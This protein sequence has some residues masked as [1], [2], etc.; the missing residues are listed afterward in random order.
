MDHTT[1]K[2]VSV[3]EQCP[4]PL[5]FPSGPV[6]KSGSSCTTWALKGVYLSSA[7][8]C[9]VVLEAGEKCDAGTCKVNNRQTGG[10]FP[11]GRDGTY[12]ELALASSDL[13]NWAVSV[14]TD[15]DPDGT[16]VTFTVGAGITR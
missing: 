11:K 12:C 13:Q 5:I 4:R 9:V 3:S 7:K 10:V 2:S 15:K 6:K 14:R 1:V 16:G 8:M